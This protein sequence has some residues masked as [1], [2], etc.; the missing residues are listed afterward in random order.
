M[1]NQTKKPPEILYLQW[2]EDEPE[3]RTWSADKIN[4][5]DVE[6]M[7]KD[8]ADKL[9]EKLENIILHPS[10][11]V[12]LIAVERKRQIQDYGAYHDKKHTEEQLVMAA[13]FY[14]YPEKYGQILSMWPWEA[15][16]NKKDKHPRIRQLTIAGAWIAAEIDRLTALEAKENVATSD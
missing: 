16:F 2:G 15:E 7:S 9:M 6:Y 13:I 5:T 4:D 11:G 14:A 3:E 12:H 10:D 8:A 1:P